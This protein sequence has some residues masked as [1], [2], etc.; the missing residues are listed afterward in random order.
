[1]EREER[2][3]RNAQIGLGDI[4][5]EQRAGRE[6][7][8]AHLHLGFLPLVGGEFPIVLVE[9]SAAAVVITTVSGSGRIA[10]AVICFTS[11]G[12]SVCRI[13][14]SGENS[15]CLTWTLSCPSAPDGRVSQKRRRGKR[16]S[17]HAPI[18]SGI[19][20]SRLEY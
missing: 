13:I 6:A 8:A 7:G 18:P 17:R 19:K 15:G 4:S 5:G 9:P 2:A 20:W 14:A 16:P 10:T 3:L 11:G 1:M 12:I